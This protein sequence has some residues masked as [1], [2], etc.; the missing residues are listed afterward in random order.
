MPNKLRFHKL[1]CT[2]VMT[3]HDENGDVL[4]E[5]AS[6][7]VTVYRPALASLPDDLLKSIDNANA[8]AIA[9]AVSAD[10]SEPPAAE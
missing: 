5:H 1:V 8:K 3:E 2:L 10:A 6:P 9:D 4:G 7:E